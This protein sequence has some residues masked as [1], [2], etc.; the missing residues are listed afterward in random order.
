MCLNQDSSRARVADARSQQAADAIVVQSAKGVQ[1]YD[2]VSSD[3]AV[4]QSC[5]GLG[6]TQFHI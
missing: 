5:K 2:I 4:V 6:D 3:G 1:S